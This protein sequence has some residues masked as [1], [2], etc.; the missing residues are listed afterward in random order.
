MYGMP[1]LVFATTNGGKIAEARGII[2]LQNYGDIQLTGIESSVPPPEETGKTYAENSEIK[3]LYYEK[4]V[5]IRDDEILFAED[6]G[7]EIPCLPDG[8]LGINSAPFMNNFATKQECFLAIKDMIIKSGKNLKS[9]PA[10]FMCDIC[11]RI[12]GKILHFNG[13]IEGRISFEH[14]SND[15][16]G[17]DPIFMPIGLDKTFAMIESKK[18][19][20]ISHRAIAL[21]TLMK[22]ILLWYDKH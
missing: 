7:L 19:N 2:D 1:R 18:K 15:G 8:M 11:T 12:D 17:Y 21:K 22:R 14:I 20:A 3:F 13:N 6:S 10:T 4:H 5:K 9:V 16:F